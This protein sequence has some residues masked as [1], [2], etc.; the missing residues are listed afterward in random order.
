MVHGFTWSF[1]DA[2]VCQWNMFMV[3]YVWFVYVWTQ[4]AFESW[5][6]FWNIRRDSR[7]LKVTQ[8]V[9][10]KS[11]RMVYQFKLVKHSGWLA[12]RM[13]EF[14]RFCH[15]TNTNPWYFQ[16]FWNR[17]VLGHPCDHWKPNNLF[18]KFGT[19]RHSDQPDISRYM[20]LFKWWFQ[21]LLFSPQTLGEN[22]NMTSIF[23]RWGWFNHQLKSGCWFE[24]F[25]FT[26]IWGNDPIWL[27]FFKWVETTN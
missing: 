16:R 8:R 10:V 27:I 11:L 9:L 3:P 7:F 21:V 24:T 1:L 5:P 15:G 14:S 6:C 12:D 25:F 26:P 17:E 23:F 2:S 22:S 20:E 4:C 18:F 19:Q 13:K